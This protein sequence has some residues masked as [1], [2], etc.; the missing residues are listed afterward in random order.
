[1]HPELFALLY[2]ERERELETELH[3]RFVQ[4]ERASQAAPR[5]PGPGLLVRVRRAVAS[6][7]A[8]PTVC[9]ATA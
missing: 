3:R 6:R 7:Q 5:R 8:A 2:Q 9:C 1:M 4:R